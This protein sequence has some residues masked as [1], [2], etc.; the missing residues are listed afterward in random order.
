MKMKCEKH[1]GFV[2]SLMTTVKW[3]DPK[4]G[5]NSQRHINLVFIEPLKKRKKIERDENHFQQKFIKKN[6]KHT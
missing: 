3:R 4:S 2:E 5:Q 6:A 1:V